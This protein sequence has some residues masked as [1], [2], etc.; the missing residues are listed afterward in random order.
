VGAGLRS[1]SPK[2][3]KAEAFTSSTSKRTP[4]VDDERERDVTRGMPFAAPRGLSRIEAAR[5]VGV[6][7]GTLDKL[8]DDRVMPKPK[9]IR[10]RLVFDR[11]E[12]D[13]AFDAIGEQAAHVDAN[14]FDLG[15]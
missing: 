14:D 10:A 13:A 12:L 5:Y 15:R 6:S 1:S 11:L 8:V 7:P 3:A 4:I 2:T 9:R